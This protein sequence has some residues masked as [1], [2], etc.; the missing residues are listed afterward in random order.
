MSIALFIPLT[1]TYFMYVFGSRLERHYDVKKWTLLWYA[2]MDNK[3]ITQF[4]I[5]KPFG[6]VTYNSIGGDSPEIGAEWG[7]SYVSAEEDSILTKEIIVYLINEGFD[8][9]KVDET[10]FYWS[11]KNT[12]SEANQLYSGANEKGESL[13]LLLEKQGNRMTRIECT[14]VF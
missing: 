8:I 11:G 9:E 1:I 3:T 5:L 12:K 7:I 2:T 4:P 6:N 10:Q 14:I 13:D